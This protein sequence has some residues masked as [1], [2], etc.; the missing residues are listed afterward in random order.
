MTTFTCKERDD[1]RKLPL[2]EV[3][4]RLRHVLNRLATEG[5]HDAD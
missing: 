4:V 3:E 2:Q 5:P 1:G